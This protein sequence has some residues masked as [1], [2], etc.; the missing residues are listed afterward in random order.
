MAVAPALD[1]FLTNTP[2]ASPASGAS[3]VVGTSP[4]GAFAGKAGHLAT[5]AEGGWRFIAPV[6]GLS[7]LD[8]ASGQTAVYRG[9]TW[10]LG[11]LR[12]GQVE[13]AGVK[14]VGSQA[15]AIADPS[16]GTTVDTQARTAL[17]AVLAALRGHGLIAP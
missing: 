5:Y 7:A 4:T 6:A 15:A 9:G 14:V 13:V 2:P 12:G 8:K 17:A 1:G 16:G 3:Y 10:E 11:K